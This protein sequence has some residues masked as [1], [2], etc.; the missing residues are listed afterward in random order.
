MHTYHQ[1]KV[2][3]GGGGEIPSFWLLMAGFSARGDQG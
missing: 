3:M 2:R 1:K